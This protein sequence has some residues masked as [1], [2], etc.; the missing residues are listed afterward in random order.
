MAAV[1]AALVLPVAA[2]AHDISAIALGGGGPDGVPA[3]V[4]RALGGRVTALDNGLYRV[5]SGEGF[6]YT[7]HGPDFGLDLLSVDSHGGGIDLTDPQR[8][9]VCATDY[10]QEV[11]YGYPTTGTNQL[12]AKKADIQ[13]M[14]R[15]NNA[16]LN[17][18]SQASG[19]SAADFKVL[20]EADDSI[21]VTAFSVNPGGDGR[22]SFSEVVNAAIAA[23]HTDA[24]ADYSIFYDGIGP[25]GVCGTASIW[26]DESPGAGN[27][28]NNPGT[29]AGGYAANYAGCWFNRTPMHENGH[30]QGAVQYNA[31]DSTGSGWHCDE[32]DDVMC[33]RDGGDLR[34]DYPQ[35]CDTSPGTMHFDCGWDSYYD[36]CPEAGEYLASSWNIGS[37]VNRFIQYSGGDV[38]EPDTTIT[39]GP[40][41]LINDASPSFSFISTEAG[42][43]E[44]SLDGAA[45]TSCSSPKAFGG[46]ADGPHAFAVR[47]ID[48]AANVDPDPASRSFT[49]DTTPP[50]TTIS[51][52]PSGA[53]NNPNPS[54]TFTSPDPG[55]GFRC[56]LDGAGY[57]PCSSPQSYSS[58]SDRAHT[59]RVEAIDAATNPDPTPASAAF[60][61]DTAPPQT[62][63][64]SGP[65][66]IKKG[67]N[68]SFWFSSSEPSSTF[69]C[70]LD[71]KRFAPCKSPQKLIKP[72]K[73]VHT[74]EVRAT[75]VLAN[76]DATPAEWTFKVKKKKHA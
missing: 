28:N 5:R 29:V 31:P 35:P 43:F 75:D 67:K 7:T 27:L 56:S 65:K 71:A 22:A 36:S 17:E 68:A 49:V 48:L 13:A 51:G 20:C 33:Y 52:G 63:L 25:S 18:E 11:L 23:G 44:C 3:T 6:S 70:R 61:V 21:K 41:G 12:A 74:F 64:H 69:E 60:T 37:T 76:V 4:E 34:Q 47:A 14:M 26:G 50:D 10:Y 58:L 55:A 46:L 1:L 16:V 57:A 42:T 38:C 66:R 40:S 9:V 39:G 45:F 19:G 54:F 15:V 62:T 8:D 32:V 24:N 72:R 30:N 59:F 53:T 73:G 2:A